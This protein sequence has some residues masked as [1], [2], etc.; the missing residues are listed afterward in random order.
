[1]QL[2][3]VHSIPALEQ[4][5][6]MRPGYAVEYDFFP[7]TQ[8][9]PTLETR[10]V[11]GLYLAGQV[12]G[13]SGYEEAAAQG[14]IAGANAALKLQGRS[15]I[16]LER[17]QAYIGVLI[18]DLVTKGTE[19]PYR[20]FTSRAEDRLFLRQDNADQRLTRLAFD[21][22]LISE[23]RWRNFQR[24]LHVLSQ[25]RQVAMETKLRGTPIRQLLKR[26]DFRIENLPEALRSLAPAE[27]W[28]LVETDWKYEG[29]AVR[30][31]SQNRTIARQN[32]QHI[33]DGLDYE[34]I[35]GLRSE[36]RQRLGTIRPTTLG[37]AARIS[38]ITPAD[39]AIISIWLSK[40]AL[41]QEKTCVDDG[42]FQTKS[43]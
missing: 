3:F 4:A 38:G 20:M 2:E 31:A 32:S 17:N 1:V 43:D 22:G 6:I 9:F 5:E 18:D 40:N 28:E 29:Y 12:N 26:P 30:Q 14:L 19:E 7:P 37:Q 34:R 15:P 36:T 13:T 42:L 11:T 33:P 41:Q 16:V 21:A 24:K 39:I 8:L 27:T 35:A 10:L 25:L 23:E